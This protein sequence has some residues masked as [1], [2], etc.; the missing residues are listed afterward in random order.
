MNHR[1]DSPKFSINV[2]WL[3]SNNNFNSYLCSWKDFIQNLLKQSSENYVQYVSVW[4]CFNNNFAVHLIFHILSEMEHFGWSAEDGGDCLLEEYWYSTALQWRLWFKCYWQGCLRLQL[5]SFWEGA[6]N[7]KSNKATN[8]IPISYNPPFQ[9]FHGI[10][11]AR[12]DPRCNSPFEMLLLTKVWYMTGNRKCR[13]L[14][15]FQ[16][17]GNLPSGF[18]CTTSCPCNILNTIYILKLAPADG[19]SHCFVQP[20]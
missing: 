5:M 15:D 4:Y 14:M 19:Y 6:N 9:A 18:L 8:P 10:S 12:P 7:L 16:T 1:G 17:G 20:E 2:Q 11:N 13:D 3:R